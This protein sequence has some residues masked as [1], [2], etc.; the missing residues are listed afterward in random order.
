MFAERPRQVRRTTGQSAV[1]P[2]PTW[3]RPIAPRVIPVPVAP[4]IPVQ[5]RRISTFL[6]FKL[7]FAAYSA[8]YIPLIRS[9]LLTIRTGFDPQDRNRPDF[10]TDAR[11]AVQ[12]FLR[13][14]AQND[15]LNQLQILQDDEY[16]I[17][18]LQDRIFQNNDT[19]Q[20]TINAC[21]ADFLTVPNDADSITVQRYLDW[22]RTDQTVHPFGPLN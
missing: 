7:T 6:F 8:W 18:A 21:S 1:D 3:P 2:A 10:W 5:P 22:V 15:L 11:N 20:S 17:P 13:T 19:F 9:A 4:Q 16:I 12:R 14:A